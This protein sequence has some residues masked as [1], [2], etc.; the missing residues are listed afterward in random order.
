MFPF[1][2][3]WPEVPLSALKK[4]HKAHFG[5]G[6]LP[7]TIRVPASP[8]HD[9]IDAKPIIEATLDDI[10]FALRG[11]EAEFNAIGDRMHA[12]RKLSQIARDT[13]GVGADRAIDAAVLAKAER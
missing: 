8:G 4:L 12:L 7:E 11:L 3:T 6:S 10:A 1:G 9:A 2:I 5:L 13:G